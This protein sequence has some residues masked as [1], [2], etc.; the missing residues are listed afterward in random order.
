[1]DQYDNPIPTRFLTPIDCLKIPALGIN[2][3]QFKDVTA[4]AV[5]ISYKLATGV[6]HVMVH[7]SP[8]SLPLS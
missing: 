8:M 7:L 1:V 3:N 6:N 2:V 4:S 5:D